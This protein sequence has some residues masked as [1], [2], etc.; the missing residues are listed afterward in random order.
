M[1]EIEELKRHVFARVG[2]GTVDG[3][4]IVVVHAGMLVVQGAVEDATAEGVRCEHAGNEWLEFD[5][6]MVEFWWDRPLKLELIG[7]EAVVSL[8]CLM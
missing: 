2:E 5:I 4:F 6:S 8:A 3:C 1:N 7:L